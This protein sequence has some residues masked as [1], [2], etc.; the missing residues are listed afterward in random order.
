MNLDLSYMSFILNQENEMS[1]RSK[2]HICYL[3][4][5]FNELI[6]RSQLLGPG[7]GICIPVKDLSWASQYI[8]DGT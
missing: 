3:I 6:S 4:K 8:L 5:Y 1:K 7:R 2:N